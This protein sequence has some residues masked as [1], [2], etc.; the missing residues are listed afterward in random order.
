MNLFVWQ[1]E[2]INETLSKPGLYAVFYNKEPDEEMIA[3]KAVEGVFDWTSRAIITANW[4]ISYDNPGSFDK[5]RE[6]KMQGLKIL[7]MKAGHFLT[8]TYRQS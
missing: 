4:R 1:E 8:E 6:G 3:I 2:A 7:N 5:Y